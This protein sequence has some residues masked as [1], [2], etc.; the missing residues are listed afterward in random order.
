[1]IVSC[2]FIL[3]LVMEMEREVVLEVGEW[4]VM[5]G[6]FLSDGGIESFKEEWPSG[7]RQQAVNLPIRLRRFESYLLHQ[8]AKNPD[9]S[10]FNAAFEYI[11]HL[12]VMNH[13]P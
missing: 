11:I 6:E 10:R 12:C 5:G 9:F 4:M 8:K 1:M 3:V 2:L 13:L 7:Q